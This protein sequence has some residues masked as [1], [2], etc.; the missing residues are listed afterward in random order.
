[1]RAWSV[2]KGPTPPTVEGDVSEVSEYAIAPVEVQGA[3]PETAESDAH[4]D[5]LVI[6]DFKEE[7]H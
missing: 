6:E 7:H 5:W 3:V 1:M 4:D 2:P